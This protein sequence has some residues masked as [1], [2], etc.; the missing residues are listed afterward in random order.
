MQPVKSLPSF[1]RDN[2]RLPLVCAPM[3]LVSGPELVISCCENG[4]L[5]GFPCPNTRSIEQLESWIKQITT[6]LDTKKKE[7]PSALI[8]P[9]LINMITHS[10]YKPFH[11]Q[12][13]LVK[14]YEPPIVITALGSPIPVID[15]VHR[16]GGLVFADVNSVPYA[17][18][19]AAT[20]VDGL[21]L[22][23]AGAGGHT[24]M[25]NPF[26]FSAEV[27]EFFSGI[28][29]ISGGLMNGQDILASQALGAQLAY[30]GTRFI[31]SEESLA[32]DEY[33]QLLTETDADDIVLTGAI[34][35]VPANFIRRTLLEAG[36][37]SKDL[38]ERRK[39]DFQE[40][41]E[42][43]GKAWRNI[44]SCGHGVG[45]INQTQPVAQIIDNLIIEYDAAR[46][47]L[48]NTLEC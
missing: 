4:V 36:Y 37:K 5:S 19:A 31:A 44:W 11:D 42:P 32:S 12:L 2:I 25:I 35:G 15:V 9:W 43:K 6:T 17:K 39:I 8:A 10:T 40:L 26:A 33:K 34:T 13:Q 47:A 30:M 28:V 38:Q 23:S 27:R 45:R 48:R 20:G 24:G 7:N 16:Y 18:K 1:I 41:A 46:S 21:V 3:F 14:K 22:V 29:L